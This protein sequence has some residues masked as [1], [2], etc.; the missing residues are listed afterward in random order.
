MR[1][2][3]VKML[4]DEKPLD[5][6]VMLAGDPPAGHALRLL[7]ELAAGGCLLVAADAGADRLAAAGC[8]PH[9]IVG[10][11]DSLRGRFPEVPRVDYPRR[12]DFTDGAA[13]L[14]LALERCGGRVWLLGALGGRPDHQL[15][16]L[17]LALNCEQPERVWL[18]G[19]DW[20]GRYLTAGRHRLAGRAGDT[21]SLLPLTPVSG[22]SLSGFEY[23]LRQAEARP[24]DSRTVSNVLAAAEGEIELR[25]G[26]LLAIRIIS[27]EECEE[28]ERR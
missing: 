19:G 25:S 14:A 20:Q 22:L 18:A 5:A 6:I 26:C 15:A 13:A 27:G 23:P 12:K 2:V 11:G 10:D 16:N 7:R 17:L 24:G 8:T 1:R 9:L 3:A 28:E 4:M 21:V